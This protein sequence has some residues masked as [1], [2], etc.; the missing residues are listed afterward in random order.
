[1]NVDVELIKLD[2]NS[3]ITGP[4]VSSAAFQCTQKALKNAECVILQPVMKLEITTPSEYSSKVYSDLTRRNSTE[5]Y[6][7]STLNDIT[8]ISAC[9]PLA[10]IAS[11]SSEIRKLTSGNTTFT[12]QFDSYKHMSQKEYNNLI[13]N[14]IL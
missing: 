8:C 9:V 10:N 1:M 3:S 5:L 13:S 11:Y 4:L 6:V 14:K 7:D 2:F 12:I